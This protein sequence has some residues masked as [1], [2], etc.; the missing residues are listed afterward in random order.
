VFPGDTLRSSRKRVAVFMVGWGAVLALLLWGGYHTGR[1]HG[2]RDGIIFGLILTA[3]AVYF[4]R[5][6]ITP[7]RPDGGRPC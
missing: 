6:S 2:V 4:G 1:L 5:D 3:V 7:P